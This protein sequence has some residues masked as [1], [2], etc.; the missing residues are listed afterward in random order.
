MIEVHYVGWVRHSTIHT[1]YPLLV[2][3]PRSDSGL[4]LTGP[5]HVGLLVVSVVLPIILCF[6]L[7]TARLKPVSL[8]RELRLRLVLFTT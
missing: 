2:T 7:L 4:L 6:A 8:S 5:I 1:R 3:Q